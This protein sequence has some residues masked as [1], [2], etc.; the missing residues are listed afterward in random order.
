MPTTVKELFD[1]FQVQELNMIHWGTE[2]SEP[3]QGIYIV[4]MSISPENNLVTMPEPSF[5]EDAIQLWINRVSAFTIDG[6]KPN[7]T[8]LKKRLTE[9]W[10]PYESILYIGKASQR[11]NGKGLGKRISEYYKTIIGDGHPH[12]GGQWIKTL[13]NLALTYVY[14]GINDAPVKCERQMP[15]HFM[16]KVSQETKNALRDKTLPLPFANIRYKPRVDK[17]HGMKNQRL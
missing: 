12:S 10:L 13:E 1:K 4:S 5:N 6:V 15:E 7:P 14:Y 8:S 3:R 16:A 11:M 9:F 2:I 17:K